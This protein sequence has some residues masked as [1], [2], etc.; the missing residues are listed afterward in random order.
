MSPDVELFPEP[1]TS[2][3]E[4][5]RATY[6]ALTQHGL[7]DLSIQQIADEAT[8]GKSTIYHHFD[9]KDDLL[10]SFVGEF[11]RAH[12][13]ALMLEL[14]ETESLDFFTYG[15]DLFILGEAADGT[16]LDELAGSEINQVYL[17]LRAQ[18]AM[19]PSYRSALGDADAVGLARTE[20][21]LQGGIDA[22]LVRA[23]IDVE[24]DAATLYALMETALLVQC[25]SDQTGWLRHIRAAADDYMASIVADDIEWPRSQVL[26]QR[27]E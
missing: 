24:Q 8:L 16:T 12:V 25:T 15:L 23:S 6:R 9:S 17:Q 27:T 13:D 1:E 7:A 10:K 11:M 26:E 22:G 3:E 2:E 5:Y 18:A 19:D 21:I 4:I 20:E 14:P